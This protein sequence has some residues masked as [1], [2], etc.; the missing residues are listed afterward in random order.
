MFWIC[1]T[2][3]YKMDSDSKRQDNEEGDKSKDGDP[4]PGT[5]PIF[6]SLWIRYSV[7]N[8]IGLHKFL[9]DYHRSI[10]PCCGIVSWIIFLFF[11]T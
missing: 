4:L 8:N 9:L 7:Q 1:L 2:N 10:L 5:L 3:K 6:Q 11:K